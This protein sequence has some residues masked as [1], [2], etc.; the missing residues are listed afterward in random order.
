MWGP[1]YLYYGYPLTSEQV[2]L[3]LGDLVKI[4]YNPDRSTIDP[5]HISA[6]QNSIRN[7]GF[8]GDY[9]PFKD[10]L[11]IELRDDDK[12]GIYGHYLGSIEPFEN[13][14]VEMSRLYQCI[15]AYKEDLEHFARSVGIISHPKLIYVGTI[16]EY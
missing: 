7:E 16:T 13:G 4:Y 5:S 15:E 3:F 8:I 9:R 1:T 12:P 6:V 2:H 10:P 14:E 11:S